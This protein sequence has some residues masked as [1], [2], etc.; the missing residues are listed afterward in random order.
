MP[1]SQINCLRM[2]CSERLGAFQAPRL[3]WQKEQQSREFASSCSTT[4]TTNAA[5]QV[6]QISATISLRPSCR[7]QYLQHSTSSYF[8]NNTTPVSQWSDE[9]M[10]DC[11][12]CGLRKS[13]TPNLRDNSLITWQHLWQGHIGLHSVENDDGHRRFWSSWKTKDALYWTHLVLMWQQQL[14]C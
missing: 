4:R 1:S 12:S 7:L 13:Y 5:V 3:W 2:A 6:T 10:A 14:F 11:Y 9:R 8:Q